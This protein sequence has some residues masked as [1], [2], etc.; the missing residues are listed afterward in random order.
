MIKGHGK[1]KPPVLTKILTNPTG[2]VDVF[3]GTP[4]TATASGEDQYGKPFAITPTGWVSSNPAAVTVSGT[5]TATL[6]FGGTEGDA[7]IKPVNPAWPATA[8]H[9]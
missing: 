9:V 4:V 2:D 3:E 6:T 7:E 1:K 8:V 5:T